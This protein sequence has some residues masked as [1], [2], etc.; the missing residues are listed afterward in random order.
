MLLSLTLKTSST[1]ESPAI[2]FHCMLLKLFLLFE[3]MESPGLV[4]QVKP[5]AAPHGLLLMLKEGRD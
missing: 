5:N 3:V 4:L 1:V 2:C